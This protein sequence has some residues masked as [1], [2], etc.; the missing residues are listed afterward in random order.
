MLEGKKNMS[1]SE[2]FGQMNIKAFITTEKINV[3]QT[4]NNRYQVEKRRKKKE[5][6]RKE[7][8]PKYMK[9]ENYVSFKM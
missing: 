1:K 3:K 9:S 8:N 7:I 5:R 4:F 6:L 2:V